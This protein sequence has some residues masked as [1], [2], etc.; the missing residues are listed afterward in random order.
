MRVAII[1]CSSGSGHTQ[2]ADSLRKGFLKKDSAIEIHSIDI[3]DYLHPFHRWL[4]TRWWVFMAH[5]FKLIYDPISKHLL[6]SESFN[7]YVIKNSKKYQKKI[8]GPLGNQKVDVVVSTFPAGAIVGNALRKKNPFLLNV[9]ILTDY[10]NRP[11]D[12]I[13]GTDIFYTPHESFNNEIKKTLK[14]AT[15]K[16]YGLPLRKEFNTHFDRDK[17]LERFCM[18][19]SKFNIIMMRGGLGFAQKFT[20]KLVIKLSDADLPIQLIV[21]CGTNR[22]LGNYLRKKIKKS[23]NP[24]HILDY[25]EE[26][27]QLMD[28][29]DI[30]LGKPGGV[31]V[32]E[33][34]SKRLPIF[35]FKS[36]GGQEDA[37][38][39]FILKH[40]LGYYE[41][42][43]SKIL[44]RISNLINEK[45][46]RYF[47]RAN[48]S[49]FSKHDSTSR[50][51]EDIIHEFNKK[52]G[53]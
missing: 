24:V 23:R 20:E 41:N 29:S 32:S 34:F 44:K 33:C 28:A 42:S 27:A 15:A 51:V 9:Q 26:V 49:L 36:L 12:L 31:A 37:N 11:F 47:F 8:I 43:H 10:I 46:L 53:K 50:I 22:K 35:A 38:V 25:T 30:F 17:T 52:I 2:V 6:F 39:N 5:Y 3:N 48:M 1:S 45:K 14:R 19:P 21:L 16:S 40:K 13:A 18:H 4:L 7:R